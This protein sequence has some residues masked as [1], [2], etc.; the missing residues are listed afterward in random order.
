MAV[1]DGTVLEISQIGGKLRLDGYKK[2]PLFSETT[3]TPKEMDDVKGAEL[4]GYSFS[5]MKIE[6]NNRPVGYTSGRTGWTGLSRVYDGLP[7]VGRLVFDENDV[8]SAGSTITVPAS[9]INYSVNGN[10]AT[11]AR[12]RTAS[13]VASTSITWAEGGKFQYRL[14]IAQTDMKSVEALKNIAD[15]ISKR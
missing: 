13:G 12:M 3:F 5:G 2:M 7:F 9:T 15:E 6:S 1:P 4:T 8:A 11:V 10:P 14:S